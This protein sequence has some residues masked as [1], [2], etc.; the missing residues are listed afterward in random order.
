VVLEP[1]LKVA[2]QVRLGRVGEAASQL[3][4]AQPSGQLQQ[5]QR[6]SPGLGDDPG[7]D[8]VVQVAGHSGRQQ[9][10]RVLVGT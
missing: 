1:V 8:P 5:P 4:F 7:A 9:S 10:A 2:R 6:V 3:G